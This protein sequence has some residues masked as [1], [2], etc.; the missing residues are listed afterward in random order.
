[1]LLCQHH[2]CVSLQ[3][4]APEAV[5]SVM[6]EKGVSAVALPLLT[7]SATPALKVNRFTTVPVYTQDGTVTVISPRGPSDLLS[8]LSPRLTAI[9]TDM[10]LVHLPIF[11]LLSDI[12]VLKNL[13]SVF[14]FRIPD[15]RTLWVH[16]CLSET[17]FLFSLSFMLHG[18]LFR[19]VVPWMLKV[20]L[21]EI[22]VLFM[23]MRQMRLNYVTSLIYASL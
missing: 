7:A 4:A 2:F 20:S 12:L 15:F 5:V 22:I 3:T 17:C 23:Q 13:K 16:C 9:H 1:V 19:F 6:A 11:T 10:K 21:L 8:S 14:C 18:L